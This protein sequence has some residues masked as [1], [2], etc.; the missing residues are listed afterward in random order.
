ESDLYMI[1]H[2]REVFPFKK[3][4]KGFEVTLEKLPDKDLSV[5]MCEVDSP[6][7]QGSNYLSIILIFLG[8]ALVF[9]GGIIA[10]I[11]TVIRAIRKRR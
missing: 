7:K 11:V 10:L 3:T 4:D 9:F 1:G 8:A 6:K 2:D 5:R